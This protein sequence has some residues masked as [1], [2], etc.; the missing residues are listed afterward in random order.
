MEAGSHE[1]DLYPRRP[2][3]LAPWPERVAAA[4]NPARLILK[5][6]QSWQWSR[7]KIDPVLMLGWIAAAM[8]G[9]ALPYRPTAFLVGDFQTGKSSLQKFVKAIFGDTL[10]QADDTTAA[11]I[12]SAVKQDSLPV[13]VDEI[14]AEADNRKVM[15][16]IKLARLAYSGGK[17]M[18]GSQDQT[19][20]QFKLQSCFLFSAINS[21]PLLPQDM[22]RM[23][24]LKLQKFD[25]ALSGQKVPVVD[26][27]TWGPMLLR[28][29]MDNWSRF[30]AANEA[31]RDVLRAGG[32]DGR[33]QDT[34]AALLACADLAL[35]PE[36]LEEFALPGEDLSPWGEWLS[37]KTMLEYEDR[38][39]NWRACLTF[40]LTA[41]VEAWRAGSQHTVGAILDHVRAV[42][43]GETYAEDG[44]SE[45]KRV[46]SMLAQ[47]DL[48]V[49]LPGEFDE[50]F[51]LAIPN[52]SQLVATLFRDSVWAGAPGASVWKSALRQAPGSVVSFDPAF[53]R[54]RI[55][56]VQ[57][58]CTLVRL[59]ALEGE[60]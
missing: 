5:A 8:L 43:N 26:A 51:T 21:P 24:V 15:A 57:R 1:G 38:S 48:R 33:G 13:A 10:V 46:Q 34:F 55:N 2:P 4:E 11:G 58:R 60:P 52:E 17:L 23:A 22:S 37:T 30:A 16:V 49:L 19:N 45:V 47:A 29:L 42:V 36:G 31:Y 39:A 3:I 6:L 50:G 40:L 14:E 25:R 32:H 20:N 44:S 18:R 7:E 56:G 59:A 9:G 35:G 53:N 12:Y 27:E 41:R 54:V 28:V